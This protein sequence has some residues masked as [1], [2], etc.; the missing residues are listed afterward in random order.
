M[1][2]FQFAII[3]HV[4]EEQKKNGEK[5]KLILVDIGGEANPKG[6]MITTI[7]AADEKSALLLAGREIPKEYLGCLD[8]IE[9]AIRPF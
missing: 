4:N 5:D 1:K 8:Q 3:W 7:L 2:L 6:R 9:I